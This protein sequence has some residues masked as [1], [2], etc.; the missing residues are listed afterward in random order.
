[1]AELN[2]DFAHMFGSDNDALYLAKYTKELADKLDKLTT[3]TDK[4]PDGLID[5]GWISDEGME[6]GF[7][8]STDDLKGYQGHG[9][10]KTFMSD[11]TT[12]FTAALLESKL[13]TVVTY[14]DGEVEKAGS[15]GAVRIKA[16]SSRQVKDLCGMVDLYDTSNEEIH[17]RYVFPHLTLGERE[18]LAFKNGDISAYNYTLKV[19]GNYYLISNAPE[20]LE[21][22][23]AAPASSGA[24]SH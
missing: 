14:L 11:S 17:F 2:A 7:D 13:Q 16:K 1:M 24:E 8:D 10:V 4:A 12:S 23:S 5:C 3:L 18:G 20:M 9:V 21:G 22:A 15:G 6:L 19:L